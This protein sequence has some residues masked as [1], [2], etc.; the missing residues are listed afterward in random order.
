VAERL[1]KYY[2]KANLLTAVAELGALCAGSSG[3][4]SSVRNSS[5]GFLVEKTALTDAQ[6]KSRYMNARYEIYLRG[7]GLFGITADTELATLE[8]TNPLL[9][10]T[11]RTTVVHV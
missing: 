9:E 3:A 8:P 6:V 11:M 5:T 7:A 1:F 10:K 4:T 2:T